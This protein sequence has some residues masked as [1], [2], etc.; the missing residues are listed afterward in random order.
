MN[1]MMCKFAMLSW[2]TLLV[3]G[4]GPDNTPFAQAPPPETPEDTI[5]AHDLTVRP[6]DAFMVQ[7]GLRLIDNNDES[8]REGVTADDF[9][10]YEGG[11]PWDESTK[12]DSTETSQFLTRGNNLP[13]KVFLVL[14]YTNSMEVSRSIDDM[15]RLTSEFINMDGCEPNA[16][17]VDEIA[18]EI[19]NEN[20]DRIARGNGNENVDDPEGEACEPWDNPDPQ[21]GQRF[22]ETHRIGLIEFHDRT[23]L[24]QGYSV[25]QTLTPMTCDGKQQLRDSIPER[26]ELEAGLTRVWDAVD[27]A[28]TELLATDQEVGEQMAIVFLTD[29]RDTTSLT[30]PDEIKTRI[31]AANVVSRHIQLYPIAFHASDQAID[32]LR[33]LADFT[34]GELYPLEDIERLKITFDNISESLRGQWNLTYVTQKNEGEVDARV[35]F[36]WR[37]EQD[38][39]VTR[40]NVMDGLIHEALIDVQHEPSNEPG[41]VFRLVAEYIPRNISE[42]ILEFSGGVRFELQSEGAL[43]PADCWTSTKLGDGIFHVESSTDHEGN[44]IPLPIGSFGV[45][46][47]VWAPDHAVDPADSTLLQVG[48][49]HTIYGDLPQAKTMLF[50]GDS[51]GL[52]RFT[53]D[54]GRSPDNGGEVTLDNGFVRNGEVVTVYASPFDG[55]RFSHWEGAVESPNDAHTTIRVVENTMITAHF[56]PVDV[57]CEGPECDTLPD[58]VAGQ[59]DPEA[60]VCGAGS[61]GA[62]ALAGL[63]L[64]LIGSLRLLNAPRRR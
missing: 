9:V 45:L 30:S 34:F 50:R 63:A 8:I 41:E 53:V 27:L 54:A 59:P 57:P 32:T 38:S 24:N 49:D 26:G 33:D 19:V 21:E 36:N 23:D 6:S 37:G 11:P 31:A 46:G 29:G 51:R 1:R 16:T 40:F 35:D 56:V 55:F 22:N 3:G 20:A 43:L 48:Y 10:I 12:L 2:T 58:L 25:R 42:F 39:F 14:D 15:V 52:G 44:P 4:C 61:A 64:L 60:R 62:A 47:R 13:L 18:I 7:L 5:Q 17:A 28:I